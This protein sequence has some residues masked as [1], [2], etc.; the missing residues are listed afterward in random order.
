MEHPP[1]DGI[2]FEISAEQVAQIQKLSIQAQAARDETTKRFMECVAQIAETGT[3]KE[4]ED[5]ISSLEQ[6]LKAMARI[7]QLTIR[8]VDA[9]CDKDPAHLR[10]HKQALDALRELDKTINKSV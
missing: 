10:W 7:M 8:N 4:P 6:E 9:L 2:L 1:E 3:Y 5:R